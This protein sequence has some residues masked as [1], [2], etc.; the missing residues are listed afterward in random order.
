[1]CCH[2]DKHILLPLVRILREGKQILIR[3]ENNSTQNMTCNMTSIMTHITRLEFVSFSPLSYNWQ[4]LR[5]FV[6]WRERKTRLK[7]N[8]KVYALSIILSLEKSNLYSTHPIY[9]RTVLDYLGLCL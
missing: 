6:F 3:I 1:M 7:T 5:S 9:C 4:T 8:T 2:R